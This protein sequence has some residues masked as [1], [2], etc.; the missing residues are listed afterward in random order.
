[1]RNI[2]KSIHNFL[3][4]H[5]YHTYYTDFIGNET[6]LWTLKSVCLPVGRL[7]ALKGGKLHFHAPIGALVF[8]MFKEHYSHLSAVFPKRFSS[9]SIDILANFATTTTSEWV[10][11]SLDII[12]QG[13]SN[14]CRS[15]KSN[16]CRY[17]CSSVWPVVIPFDSH[18]LLARMNIKRVRYK[19]KGNF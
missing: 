10:D 13:I 9:P 8:S 2:S 12:L 19:M 3:Y 7:V 11:F 15:G 5:I 18:G 16:L 14:Y 4:A 1:M 17:V 6:S